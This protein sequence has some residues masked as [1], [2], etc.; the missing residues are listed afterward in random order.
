MGARP[1]PHGRSPIA[2][3]ALTFSEIETRKCRII[4]E[5]AMYRTLLATCGSAERVL[6]ITL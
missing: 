2:P 4:I 1:P 5:N 3:W 6:K